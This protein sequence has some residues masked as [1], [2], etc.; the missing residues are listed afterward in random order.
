MVRYIKIVFLSR[1]LVSYISYISLFFSN[2][3]RHVSHS[4]TIL[5]Y[6]CVFAKEKGQTI[7]LPLFC[8][9]EKLKVSFINQTLNMFYSCSAYCTSLLCPHPHMH[10]HNLGDL[11]WQNDFQSIR[12]CWMMHPIWCIIFVI[13]IV[14]F[15][16]VAQIIT[17]TWFKPIKFVYSQLKY[18]L[19][20]W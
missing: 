7:L 19:C 20:H 2:S 14:K 13:S 10:E 6:F 4:F 16:F 18:I 11:W 1:F 5:H 9:L 15:R 12:T 17:L 8:Y 3:P